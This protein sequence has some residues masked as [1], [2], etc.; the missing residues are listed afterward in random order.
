M[1]QDDKNTANHLYDRVRIYDSLIDAASEECDF[2]EVE[3]LERAQ[4]AIRAELRKIIG[5]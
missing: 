4:G 1:S 2:S 5:L 3:R